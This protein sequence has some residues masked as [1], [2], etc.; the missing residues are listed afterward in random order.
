MTGRILTVVHQEQSRTGRVGQLLEE[1][2]YALERCCPNL[3]DALPDPA[4]Y[5]G[6]VI[7]GGPMSAND[8]AT[9]EGIRAEMAW[10]PAVLEA[11]TPF[12]GICLGAQML[13][14]VLG[15]QVRPHPEG[16]AEIGYSRVEPVRTGCRFF[17]E[18]LHVYQW[19]REGFDMPAGAEL[20]ARG[21]RFPHQ[22]FRYGQTAFGL[23]FHPEVTLEM[24]EV[25]TVK[26]AERLT[27]PGAQPRETH[28]ALHEVHD[29]PLGAWIGRFLDLWLGRAPQATARAT[30]SPACHA[31]GAGET[32]ETSQA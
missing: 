18:P 29:P 11:G 5:D 20:L 1:R 26:A 25:W 17:P 23:Q 8:E 22:A 19:H 32:P 12:L 21:D 13:A 10:L 14:R 6:V 16:L 24:K 30:S 3:G 28:L 9:H 31:A 7:F 2:G 15:A 4:E 27:L